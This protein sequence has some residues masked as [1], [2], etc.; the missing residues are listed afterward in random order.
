[1]N[2]SE[3]FRMRRFLFTFLMIA[4][5][6]SA[7]IPNVVADIPAVQSLVASVMGDLGQPAL[8]L[9]QGADA[10]DYQMRPSGAR[11]LADADAVFWIGPEMTPWLDR[12]L[13]GG[14][15]ARAT[16]LLK[17]PGT[18]ILAFAGGGTDPHAFLDP[19]NAA[20]W[21]TLIADRLA[22]LDPDNAAVYRANARAEAVHIAATD[23]GIAAELSPVADRPIIVFHDAFGY[24]AARYR[25]N[26]TGSVTLGDAADPGAARLSALRTDLAGTAC[27]FP[28]SGHDPKQIVTLADGT[29]VRIGPPLDPEGRDL[30]PGPGLYIDLLA[31]LGSA[32]AG[33]LT[34]P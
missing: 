5:P 11:A 27:I 23:A 19:G 33:C 16:A 29:P 18:H 15:P 13:E 22:A 28:E 10:H 4:A 21:L 14:D 26:I 32:I 24:F 3:G 1:M 30:T 31:N 12:A 20:L 25:L 2:A 7:D 34:Q 6:A 17:V 8:L 9:G